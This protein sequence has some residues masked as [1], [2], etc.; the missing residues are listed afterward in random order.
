MQLVPAG[1]AVEQ[2]GVERRAEGEEQGDQSEGGEEK[3][4]D[5]AYCVLRT[6]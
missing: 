2:D 1:Q 3:G 4:V 6:A 5:G